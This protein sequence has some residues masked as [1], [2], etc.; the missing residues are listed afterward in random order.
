M[1]DIHRTPRRAEVLK[2][3]GPLA[4]VYENP[5]N[6]TRSWHARL[7]MQNIDN[8]ALSLH[9]ACV[10][11]RV[12]RKLGG[13]QQADPPPYLSWTAFKNTINFS[14]YCQVRLPVEKLI[15]SLLKLCKRTRGWIKLQEKLVASVVSTIMAVAD[16]STLYSS[17]SPMHFSDFTP[18]RVTRP[19]SNPFL[20]EHDPVSN[21]YD[22][23]R[24][25][26][27]SHSAMVCGNNVPLKGRYVDVEF[28]A[29]FPP[30]GSRS[31]GEKKVEIYE[32]VRKHSKSD[33]PAYFNPLCTRKRSESKRT[34]F[35][36]KQTDSEDSEEPDGDVMKTME[37]PTFVV[38]ESTNI[39]RGSNGVHSP[40]SKPFKSA[41]LGLPT[42]N[43][44]KL[45]K[46]RLSPPSTPPPPPPPPPE[47][48][49]IAEPV[50]STA[51]SLQRGDQTTGMIESG[52]SGFAAGSSYVVLH[53]VDGELASDANCAAISAHERA[54]AAE[55]T[56]WQPP[57]NASSAGSPAE[58]YSSGSSPPVCRQREEEESHSDSEDGLTSSTDCDSDGDSGGPIDIATEPIPIP[59]VR[60]H[61]LLSR[62]TPSPPL[63]P[64]GQSLP[65]GRVPLAATT[66]PLS[67]P[68]LLQNGGTT[69]PPP[70]SPPQFSPLP[71][72]S[73]PQF[74]PPPLIGKTR[75]VPPPRQRSISQAGSIR[76]SP[77]GRTLKA[78]HSSPAILSE[79]RLRTASFF[80]SKAGEDCGQ[81]AADYLG[82]R[83]IDCYIGCVDQVAKQ[84]VDS[85]SVEV[86][87]Y[88]TSEK[89]RL[90][91]PKSSA[92]LFKSFAMKDILSVEKCSKNKRIVGVLVWKSRGIPSCHILRCPTHIIAN[93]LYETIWFQSQNI[94]EVMLSKVFFVLSV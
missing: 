37:T 68:P 59:T 71:S 3:T 21:L 29:S 9:C 86:I 13:F 46:R 36:K 61:K 11:P 8:V 58:R 93:S 32:E 92:L 30:V 62:Y 50:E 81:Y 7:T 91:P 47:V 5:H 75:P 23:V 80:Q 72:S 28:A 18:S 64:A 65:S 55:R 19:S 60:R 6:T 31:P 34:A 41:P 90:A 54:T 45:K 79:G 40:P 16:S 89:V 33:P 76:Y 20:Q 14:Q 74:S 69:S 44:I 82:C 4:N 17:L 26:D 43:K 2:P 53:R 67:S 88:V 22:L 83:E 57:R 85:K 35:R 84:L 78:M 15:N 49:F 87:A 24:N 42:V 77:D 39:S 66:P 10:N 70:L 38:F 27:R 25:R 94:D 73:A 1:N 52:V 63:W 12:C 51:V 48:A 56:E